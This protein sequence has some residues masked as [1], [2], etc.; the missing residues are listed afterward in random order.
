MSHEKKLLDGKKDKKAIR[1][2]KEK[3]EEKKAKHDDIHHAR[4]PRWQKSIA[5]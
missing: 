1:T 4:K 5:E 3:R 2:L